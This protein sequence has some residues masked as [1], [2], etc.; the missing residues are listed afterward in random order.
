MSETAHRGEPAKLASIH[1]QLLLVLGRW[2]YCHHCH[3][4]T[5]M[6]VAG[7]DVWRR[8]VYRCPEGHD[9]R[10]EFRRADS[11]LGRIDKRIR[12][13]RKAAAED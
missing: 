3:A 10:V 8:I 12:K 4:V 1:P 9:V 7:R 2:I 6:T 13:R 11:R 5:E